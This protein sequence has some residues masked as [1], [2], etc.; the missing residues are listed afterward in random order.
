MKWKIHH[1]AETAST[2][3]DARGGK[4]GDVFTAGYQSAGRGR[5]DHKWLS[6]PGASLLM[7]VVL[8]V[9]G[10]SPERIATLPLAVGF[11][12]LEA[13]RRYAPDISLKWPNDILRSG[14]KL[15]GILCELCGNHAIAGIG[16][17]VKSWDW[18]AGIQAAALDGPSTEETRDAIL[19]RLAGVFESWRE[20]GISPFMDR[21]AACDA[22]KGK[23]IEVMRIDGDP[24]PFS[25]V[26]EGIAEDGAL[27][28][29][30]EKVYAGEVHIGTV[31]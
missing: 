5:L 17:N 20:G 1:S 8:D 23:Q 18:P 13:L 3:L 29:S 14:R 4:P 30:G 10:I 11:A 26:A 16:V 7:S 15:A 31:G 2:N 6:P 28:V 27:V 24:E 21:L 25:G 22:L 9:G 19:D 12:T